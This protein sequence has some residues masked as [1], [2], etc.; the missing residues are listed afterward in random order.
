MQID[1]MQPHL[2]LGEGVEP[3]FLSTPL[4]IIAPILEQF[5]HP[6]DVGC[7]FEG[8]FRDGFETTINLAEAP[9][10]V[11]STVGSTETT[12]AAVTAHEVFRLIFCK[13]S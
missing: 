2:V 5:S 10:A 9:A 12:N 7:A 3:R 6:G 8:Q 11:R 4:K 13:S 1:F